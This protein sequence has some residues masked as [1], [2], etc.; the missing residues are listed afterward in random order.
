MEQLRTRLPGEVFNLQ[1][2]YVWF[3]RSYFNQW[4]LVTE[5]NFQECI[6]VMKGRFY[7]SFDNSLPRTDV[8]D[9]NLA[10]DD[11][12]CGLFF[13]A[14]HKTGLSDRDMNLSASLQLRTWA[15]ELYNNG[16]TIIFD[17]ILVL[18][19]EFLTAAENPIYNRV[20]CLSHQPH[21]NRNLSWKK[22][23]P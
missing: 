12:E 10:D 15:A 21:K 18:F 3:R 5:E 7:I 16:Y 23:L 17:E 19:E 14:F 2:M 6:S 13:S 4:Q 8:S 9:P 20:I 22:Q 1:T 11:K